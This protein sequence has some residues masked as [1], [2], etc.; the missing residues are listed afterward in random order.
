MVK[1]HKECKYYLPCGWCDKNNEK[2]IFEQVC[3]ASDA[4]KLVTDTLTNEPGLI[5]DYV[6]KQLAKD[7]SNNP[8][9]NHEWYCC[10]VD[11]SGWTYRCSKCGQ[12]KKENY[13]NFPN[14]TP[15]WIN[16]QAPD[17]NKV[18]DFPPYTEVTCTGG[19]I[20]TNKCPEHE[21]DSILTTNV[22]TSAR[23]EIQDFI[24]QV[25]AG[26]LPKTAESDLGI[27]YINETP[28]KKKK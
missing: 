15:V 7:Y 6:E 11:T 8:I 22:T 16:P 9:C 3:E 20:N 14:I 19:Y 10:G 21:V 28:R 2:C 18:G 12:I 17:I 4:K 13:Q 25:N 1:N 23:T 27:Q 26:N 24:N 5:E